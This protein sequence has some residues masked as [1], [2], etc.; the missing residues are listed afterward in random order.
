MSR[1]TKEVLAKL[2]D[3]NR[4]IKDFMNISNVQNG[5]ADMHLY[6][7]IVSNEFQKWEDTDIT[8]EDMQKFLSAVA[9]VEK[10]NVY[11]NS[12][13][14]SVFAGMAIHAMLKRHKAE[15][16]VHIDGVAASIAGVIAMAGD[17]IVMA[18]N[19][20]IMLHKPMIS[21]FGNANDFRKAIEDLDAIEEGIM[22]A[23]QPKLKEG[24]DIETVR[25]LVDAETWLSGSKAAEYFNVELTDAN[26][27][28]ACASEFFNEYE[29][30]PEGIKIDTGQNEPSDDEAKRLAEEEAA[31]EEAK[32]EFEARL[33]LEFMASSL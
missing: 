2:A 12:A 19:A 8:P 7:D 13:G 9:D 3:K 32:A 4:T 33:E 1:A 21:A 28:A 29:S 10:L 11:I 17:R 30:I 24:V 26:E 14:G 20:Y 16:T 5:S 23:Y 27:M 18:S 22:N 25:S 6:G 31:E 15:I